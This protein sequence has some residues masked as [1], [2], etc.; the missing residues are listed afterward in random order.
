MQLAQRARTHDPSYAVLFIDLDGFK[1]VNDSLGHSA[2][3]TFLVAI[4][5]RLQTRLRGGDVLARF[6]GDEFAVLM[7]NVASFDD[8]RHVSERL[9]QALAEPFDIEGREIYASASIG[10][11]LWRRALPAGQ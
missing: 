6:G 2:G 3:D 11:A 8:V 7:V 9:Q 5:Q 1:L 10:I 4:A